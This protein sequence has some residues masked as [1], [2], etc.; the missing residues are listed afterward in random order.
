MVKLG[1]LEDAQTCAI[2]RGSC[3]S[4]YTFGT[5]VSR[6]ASNMAWISWP[7]STI[8]DVTSIALVPVQS[9]LDMSDCLSLVWK[10][11]ISA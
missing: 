7:K 8:L 1:E 3:D 11:V 9:V 5:K 2:M 6:Y 10:L 4:P